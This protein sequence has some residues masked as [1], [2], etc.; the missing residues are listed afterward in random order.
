MN[1]I[2]FGCYCTIEQ[3]RYG[4]PN[5][6]YR[7]K[8]VGRKKSNAWTDVP[9]DA[10]KEKESLHADMHDVVTVVCDNLDDRTVHQF[11]ICDLASVIKPQLTVPDGFTLMPKEIEDFGPIAEALEKGIVRD[12]SISD[13]YAC[14][15]EAHGDK[16]E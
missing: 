3:K 14:A 9:V 2:G 12:W 1:D 16:N 11:R 4:V 10:N 7:Y 5:E 8:V 6:F 13:I 15:I